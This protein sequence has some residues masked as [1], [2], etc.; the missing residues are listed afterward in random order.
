MRR[1]SLRVLLV[2]LALPIGAAANPPDLVIYSSGFAVVRDS[3]SLDLQPGENQVRYG[4]VTE[5]IDPASVILRDPTGAV[6]LHILEQKFRSSAL[7][8]ERM[9]ELFEGQTIPFR[10]YDQAG[11]REVPA[12]IVRAKTTERYGGYAGLIIEMEGK[13]LFD[14]PGIPVF[15]KLEEGASLTPEFIWTIAAEK[16]AKVNAELVYNTGGLG[17]T[18]DYNAVVTETGDLAQ[19]TGWITLKNSTSRTFTDATVKAVAGQINKVDPEKDEG[20]EATTERVIV[21]GSYVPTSE[22]ESAMPPVVERKTFD[23]YHEYALQRPVTLSG[24][25]STQVEF[26][27]ASGIK[28]TRSFVYSGAAIGGESRGEAANLD[29]HYGTSSNTRVVILSEFKNDEASHLGM[30]LPRGRFHFYRDT[31][32]RLQF[33]GESMVGNTPAGENVRAVSGNAFDLVGERRQVDFKVSADGKTAEELFEIKLRNHR[34]EPVEIRVVEP[35]A[36]WRQWEIAA[37]SDEFRKVDARTFEF[38]VP[39]TGN[40]EKTL[41][42]T[43]RYT[44]LPRRRE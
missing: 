11:T 12:K 25:E 17:W 29:P 19:L 41:T 32:Q 22:T 37:K 21:T 36:R 28:A 24:K 23:E 6:P 18:A 2:S 16:A 20:G 42:Y 3:V 38:R 14:M 43:I 9:L 44:Q 40:G 1:L 7:K 8:Q 35:A 34:A 30:P 39:V 26:V 10:F 27:S 4:L 13:Y 15:P 33:T 5:Q 31:D